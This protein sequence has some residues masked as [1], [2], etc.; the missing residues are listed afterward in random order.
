M[1][2]DLGERSLEQLLLLFVGRLLRSRRLRLCLLRL[3]GVRLLGRLLGGLRLLCGFRL[4]CGSRL[5]AGLCR[6]LRRALLR[7][8]CFQV[9]ACTLWGFLMRATSNSMTASTLA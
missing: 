2:R 1:H 8:A 6:L 3:L 9:R 7:S 4:L 5:L